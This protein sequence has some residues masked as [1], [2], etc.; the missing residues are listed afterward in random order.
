M[1]R[2]WYLILLLIICSFTLLISSESKTQ[3]TTAVNFIGHL[4]TLAVDKIDKDTGR[5]KGG[6]IHYIKAEDGKIYQIEDKKGI[7]GKIKP[8]SKISLSGIMRKNKI[9]AD[10]V[11]QLS[12]KK[13]ALSA[14]ESTP[15]TI[16]EQKTLV[17]LFNYPD[18]SSEPFTIQDVQNCVINNANS[19]DNF[20]RE[21][22]YDKTW[23]N[24]DFIDW[25]TLP[26]NSTYYDNDDYTDLLLNDSITILDPEINFQ[27][28]T[29]LIFVYADS[30]A[31]YGTVGKR[32]LSSSGDG[33]FNASVSWINA[34]YMAANKTKTIAHEFGHNLGFY[35]ANVVHNSNN[36]YFV[37]ESLADP[38]AMCG[39]QYY[40]YGDFDDTMG[41][42]D[43]NHFSTIWKTQA[44]WIDAS[45]IQ[46][47]KTSGEYPL[48]QVEF[49]SDG[50]KVLRVPLGK[51]LNN[52]EFYYWI[53]YRKNLGTFDDEDT[54]QIR[55]K[56]AATGANEWGY[57]TKWS[58]NK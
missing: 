29:R 3:Q 33:D 8:S 21:N 15:E 18:K 55:T 49:P 31:S 45:Q 11:I 51:D 56:L 54:V 41:S 20:I 47:V 16:G 5:M 28:Y 9:V 35:H 42:G 2:K 37:T 48:D 53:E 34:D 50:I 43:Y 14:D 24:A 40:N 22:S 57:D 12:T 6:F 13:S 27:N 7:L 38:T 52:N 58:N 4:Q 36:P 17:A 19:V 39:T 1:A 26:N 46:D 30:G 25:H 10:S 32:Y 23:L 44:Q